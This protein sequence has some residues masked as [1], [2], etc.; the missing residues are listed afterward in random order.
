MKD[1]NIIKKNLGKY[2]E[3]KHNINI[4]KP[5]HCFNPDHEDVHPSMSY[6]EKYGICKCFSG[7]VRYDIF[8]LIG[9]DYGTDN[10]RDQLSIAQ[11]FFHEKGINKEINII[12]RL[13]IKN[14]NHSIYYINCMKNIEKTDY[15][16]TRKIDKKLIKKYHIGYDI[17]DNTI[18]FPIN[19]FCYF[20]RGTLDDT[21]IKS[22]GLS[23]LWN[24]DLIN[25]DND[26]IYITESIIDGLSLETI[27]EN[28]KVVSLNGLPNYKR[29]IR[30]IQEEDYKGNLVL[31][32]DNDKT[33]LYYL[34]KVKKELDDLNINS[35][36]CTLISNIDDCKDINEALMKDRK[37]LESNYE[38]FNDNF[39]RIIEEK[40]KEK[41]SELE[42]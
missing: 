29:L 8:D 35:F 15:L 1:L 10:F 12:P 14:T 7:G 27:D 26:L 28:V 6:S 24:E 9:I 16:S 42:L 36:S 25:N 37:K 11:D 17:L 21:K 40:N 41:G 3:L 4:N 23:Y 22:T 20:K 39:R 18:V 19:P 33:G 30:I 5:F 13:Y 2:L 31:A 32:F 38:Y 34:E